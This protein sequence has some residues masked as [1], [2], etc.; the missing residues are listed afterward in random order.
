M[1]KVK[2]VA[3]MLAAGMFLTT[4]VAN[5]DSHDSKVKL[6][7]VKCFL[8]KM[9]VSE[10]DA[11]DYQGGKVYFGC[12]GCPP[13]FSKNVAKYAAKANAQLVATHQVHQKSCPIMGG[14]VKSNIKSKVAGV[15]V[16]FCCAKCKTA[17]DKLSG[18][19][20]IEKV[21]GK[22]AFAK[23]FKA[24]KHGHDHGDGHDHDHK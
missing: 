7:G 24:G 21:F 1:V 16:A 23:G 4:A 14:K 6:K 9:Q 2:A 20:Q 11:V 10:K 8:C 17:V 3:M 19:A 18:D 22:K 13:K 5:A 15:D 12:A